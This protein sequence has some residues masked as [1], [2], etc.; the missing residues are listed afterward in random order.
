MSAIVPVY[1]ISIP[2]QRVTG[3]KGIKLQLKISTSNSSIIKTITYHINYL[4]CQTIN[5]FKK[6]LFI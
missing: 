3:Y 2:L 4:S 5:K 1:E 6:I